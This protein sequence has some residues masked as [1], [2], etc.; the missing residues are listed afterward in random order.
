LFKKWIIGIIILSFISIIITVTFTLIPNNHQP[1]YSNIVKPIN[2]LPIIVEKKEVTY[3]N[4]HIIVNKAYALPP[5]YKPEENKKARYQLNKLL[6]KAKKKHL[7]LKYISGYRSYNE[8]EEVVKSYIE[9]EG[10]RMANQYTAKPGH[11][12]HQSG[13]AF[14][15][16]TQRHLEDFHNDF[17]HTK[18]AKWLEKNASKYGFIIRY[19]KGQSNETGYAYEAWHLRYVGSELAKIIDNQDTNLESYYKLK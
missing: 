17:E 2:T 15:V 7:D 18:E 8:Q 6:E 11:S 19:P 16:G 1:K 3:V 4:G 12:E 10:K 5:D 13:L 9:E 14:D